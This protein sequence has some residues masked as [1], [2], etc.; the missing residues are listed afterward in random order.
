MNT[1]LTKITHKAKA[2]RKASPKMKWATAVK[3]A[4]ADYRAG[5]LGKATAPKKKVGAVKK[6]IIASVPRKRV[7]SVKVGSTRSVS[8]AL[9]RVGTAKAVVGK[10]DKLEKM[11]LKSGKDLK[12][13]IQ[14]EIN[15]LHKQLSTIEKSYRKR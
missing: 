8:A 6:K 10:I 4:S 2:I 12:R 14:L 1:A 11:R 3:M 13:V 7:T 5:K 15:Q 9:G